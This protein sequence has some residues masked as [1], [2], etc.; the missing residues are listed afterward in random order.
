MEEV[1]A[2]F[3]AFPMWT[4]PSICCVSCVGALALDQA[5]EEGLLF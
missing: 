3:E 1:E 4:E 2:H 5:K